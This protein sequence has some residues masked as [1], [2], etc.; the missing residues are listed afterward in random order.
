MD[1]VVG[2]SKV[3]HTLRPK[4][5]NVQFCGMRKSFGLSQIELH[6]IFAL[7]HLAIGKQGWKVG[8]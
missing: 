2:I 3:E 8:I 5:L 4:M 1:V 6:T 7:Y